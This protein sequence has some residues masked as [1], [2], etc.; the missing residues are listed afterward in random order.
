MMTVS[1]MGVDQ[2]WRKGID[3]IDLYHMDKNLKFDKSI[4]KSQL[5]EM[6]RFKYSDHK[7]NKKS[8]YIKVNSNCLLLALY[9]KE[10]QK[11]NDLILNVT[12]KTRLEKQRLYED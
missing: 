11:K 5:N 1:D 4:D 10:V 7:G 2:D 3:H 6:S 8:K 9:I 12:E